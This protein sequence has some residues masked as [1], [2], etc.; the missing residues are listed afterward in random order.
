MPTCCL[1]HIARFIIQVR[2][3]RARRI[4]VTA[5]SFSLGCIAVML[6]G[7]TLLPMKNL[8]PI[9][10][11]PTADACT[12]NT[13]LL[14][15]EIPPPMQRPQLHYILP[16]DLANGGEH[17][18]EITTVGSFEEYRASVKTRVDNRLP[19]DLANDPVT[20]QFR[21]FL[22]SV[23]GEAQLDAQVADHTATDMAIIKSERDLIKKYNSAPNLK[24][25]ALKGFARKVFD[26][27]KHGP[28]DFIDTPAPA[29][30]RPRLD[31]TFAAYMK[32]YYDGMFVDRM[33][34]TITKPD[35]VSGLKN[36]PISYSVPDAEIVAAETVLLEFIVDCI[37]PTPVMGDTPTPLKTTN[38][39]PGNVA[40]EP[41]ALTTGFAA[42]GYVELQPDGCGINLKNVW[43]LKDLAS[44]A[45]DRVGAIGGLIVNTPGGISIGLGIVGKISIGDNQT[46]SDLVK[47]AASE[48]ALRATLATSYF[49]LRRVAFNP[50]L[51]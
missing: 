12:G 9:I 15:A 2:I 46:L 21:E 35:F 13:G 40:S 34:N 8:Q 18:V 27:L 42:G 25:A 39:F 23:S 29:G 4:R 45:S 44:A 33:G 30:T 5:L 32:A 48:L 38:Y 20:T 10:A 11:P 49:T 50:I 43:V 37:D 31:V 3:P 1:S 7:C 47:A 22:T 41:T 6:S 14:S 17:R 26:L 36:F 28:G 51:P 24:Q 19:A 16:K